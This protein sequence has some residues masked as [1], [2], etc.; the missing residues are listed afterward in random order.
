MIYEP[1]LILKWN[2][3]FL[4]SVAEIYNADYSI[5]RE[6]KIIKYQNLYPVNLL[7]MKQES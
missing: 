2:Y 1:G 4:E 3:A 6:G 7:S 5:F